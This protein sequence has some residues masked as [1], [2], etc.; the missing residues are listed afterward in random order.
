MSRTPT[1]RILLGLTSHDDLGGLRPTGFYVSEAAHPWEVF[2][3][4]GYQVD[5]ASTAGGRPPADGV[6]LDDPTQRAFL[7]D[8]QVAAALADTPRL[9]DV[10][11]SGY[12]AVLF[13]GGHGTMWDF[14]TDPGPG[15]VAREVWEQGGVVAAVC[16]G[17]A[18]LVGATLS[19]GSPLVAGR[20]VAAFTN[21]E[22]E[23]AGLTHVM[24]FLLQDRLEELGARHTAAPA[25][26]P[27][28]V[29]DGRLV[30]GQNPASAAGVAEAVLE[31][32][33]ET[34]ESGSNEPE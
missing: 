29:S 19:N 21:A 16:H 28:V 30:T 33:S 34:P 18:A 11:P 20:E 8:P 23:A 27:H 9:S 32:L 17:P 6:D 31:V 7:D 3:K 14:P 10:D 5:L 26:R 4:A 2:T 24:P 13:A 15:R 12:D 25:F 1:K 22:E